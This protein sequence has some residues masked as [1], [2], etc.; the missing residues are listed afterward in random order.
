MDHQER[1]VDD[2]V[3]IPELLASTRG[4]DKHRLTLTEKLELASAAQALILEVER[5]WDTLLS[6]CW[7]E[8]GLRQ[9]C[10]A[11][12]SSLIPVAA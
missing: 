8:V 6:M 7:S 5:P 9:S 3:D 1:I 10:N 4:V 2:G 12:T 11:E